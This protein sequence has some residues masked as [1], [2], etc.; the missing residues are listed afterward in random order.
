LEEV[1][2]E[3]AAEE[4][5]DSKRCKHNM[6]MDLRQKHLRDGRK[7]PEFSGMQEKVPPP[8]P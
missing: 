3:V 8:V 6:E 2:D 7:V 4:I 5:D 1:S